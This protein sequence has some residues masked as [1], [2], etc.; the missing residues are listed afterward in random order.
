MQSSIA[1]K[2]Y[3]SFKYWVH[4]EVKWVRKIGAY[5]GVNSTNKSR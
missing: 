1:E 3:A 4:R 5:G 2:K